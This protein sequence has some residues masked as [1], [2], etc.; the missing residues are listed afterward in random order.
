MRQVVVLAEAAE[1]LEAAREFYDDREAGL[2]NYCVSSLL[3]DIESLVLYHGVHQRQYDCLRMLG[4]RFPFGIYDLE[5]EHQTQVVA[6]LDLRRHPGWIRRQVK[7]RQ[8]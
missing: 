2:G 6:V 7:Q 8:G 5:A 3:A 1:D 4:T